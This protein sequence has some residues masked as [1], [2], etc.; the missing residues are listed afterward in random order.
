ML[1]LTTT[2]SELSDSESS[3]ASCPTP[4]SLA[5]SEH[6]LVQDLRSFIEELRTSSQV[7][8]HVSRFPTQESDLGQTTPATCG[9]QLSNVFASYDPDTRCWKMSQGWL[10]A[11]ISGPSWETWPKAG[12]VLNGEFYPQ[13]N[14]E[15][16]ISEIGCGLWPTATA[17]TFDIADVGAMMERRERMKEK[18]GN[19]NGFGLTLAQ[20]V[21]A[22]VWPT[23]TVVTD[24]GGPGNSGRDG[25]LNL[26]TAVKQWP[27]PRASEAE[28]PG[29]K[30]NNHNGQKG[31]AEAVNMYPTPRATDYKGAVSADAMTKAADRGYSPNLPEQ[32]AA[33]SGGG[34]L[35]PDW[36]EW[37]MG[38]PI[39]F[40]SLEPLP[41]ETFAQWLDAVTNGTWWPNEPDIPRVAKGITNRV[42]RLKALGNGQVSAVVAAAWKLL[43]KD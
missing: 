13:P 29:R 30:S 41:A 12:C 24:T 38:W 5:M 32:I 14:W 33:M 27:T 35:N 36:V 2:A 40:T 21:K 34:Q 28:H 42:D 16:R 22:Q 11:D 37:L 3:T 17:H 6:S 4:P 26:R 7:A 15:R 39:G 8:S 1:N 18:H 10:L 19:G 9:L 23:P 31:L 25:G 43:T 20:A